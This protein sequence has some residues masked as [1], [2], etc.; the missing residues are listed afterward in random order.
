MANSH[1]NNL[2][3]RYQQKSNVLAMRA[4][5]PAIVPYSCL[6]LVGFILIL[7]T[8]SLLSLPNYKLGQ[9]IKTVSL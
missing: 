7:N 3:M 2:R 6:V 5:V 1:C 9:I 8:Q 4:L